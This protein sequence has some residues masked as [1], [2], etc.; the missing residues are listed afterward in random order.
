MTQNR[1]AT[2][3]L[4][5]FGLPPMQLIDHGIPSGPDRVSGALAE[6]IVVCFIG[7]RLR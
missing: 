2:P 4:L 7:L 1:L 3:Q 6:I 5:W